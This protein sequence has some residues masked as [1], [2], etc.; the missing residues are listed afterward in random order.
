MDSIIIKEEVVGGLLSL[1]ELKEED[2]ND[3]ES[4]KIIKKYA[5]KC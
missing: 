5:K 3:I 4:E 2:K 1:L